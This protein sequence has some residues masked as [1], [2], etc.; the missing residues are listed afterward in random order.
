LGG[1]GNFTILLFI[2]SILTLT[3]AVL[4]GYLFFVGGGSQ[5]N[6][7][8]KV[9]ENKVIEIPDEQRGNYQVFED[10]QYFNLKDDEDNKDSVIIIEKCI[11]IYDKGKKSKN[12]EGYIA[13]FDMYKNEISEKIGIYFQNTTLSQVKQ[14]NYVDTVKKD[15]K[16]IINKLLNSSE[17]A[18]EEKEFVHDITI[19]WFYQ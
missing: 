9:V 5:K 6:T 2:I 7:V 1:K 11:L 8:T 12:E 14:A 10:K 17:K 4:A 13:K 15:L 19:R 18:G 16:E 3:L